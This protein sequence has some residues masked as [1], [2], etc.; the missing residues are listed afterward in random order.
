[1]GGSLRVSPCKKDCRRLRHYNV[2]REP[3]DAWGALATRELQEL[4]HRVL[5]PKLLN[6]AQPYWLGIRARPSTM[7]RVYRALGSTCAMP[8]CYPPR[9]SSSV[10]RAREIISQIL[11]F[12]RTV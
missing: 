5:R 12:K 9:L 7:A 2:R 11:L 4:N 10:R 3:C 6:R 8:K 1:M